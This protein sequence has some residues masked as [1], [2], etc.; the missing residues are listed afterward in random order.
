MIGRSANSTESRGRVRHTLDRKTASE[1]RQKFMYIFVL[2]IFENVNTTPNVGSYLKTYI[3]TF[4]LL[5]RFNAT[6]AIKFVLVHVQLHLGNVYKHIGKL[7][8][9][10]KSSRKLRA[11][12]SFVQVF[13]G[14]FNGKCTTASLTFSCNLCGA[15][16]AK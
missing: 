1:L 8:T 2:T 10:A 11:F 9:R 14:H 7:C 16:H 4:F 12:R 15:L 3:I 6:A 5:L 13:Q